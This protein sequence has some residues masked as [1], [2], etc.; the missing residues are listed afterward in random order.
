MTLESYELK[1]KALGN[2]WD[3]DNLA[4]PWRRNSGNIGF[5]PRLESFLT[6]G[7]SE[8]ASV[9]SVSGDATAFMPCLCAYVYVTLQSYR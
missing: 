6:S 5:M 2:E 4:V 8:C 3:K 1:L 9:Y 7:D